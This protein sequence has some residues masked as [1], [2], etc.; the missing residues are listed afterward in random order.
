MNIYTYLLALGALAC[1]RPAAATGDSLRYLVSTDTVM[2]EIA[3]DQR[4]YTQHTFAPKQTL[5]S[6]S[7]FYAQDIDQLIELNP[8]L[9]KAQP[10]IGQTVKVAVP[11]VAITRY[12]TAGF[13]ESQYSKVCYTVRPGET[14][15]KIAR[16]IFRMPVDTL[17]AVNGLS[18]TTLSPG[19]VLQVG[20]MNVEGAASKIETRPLDPLQRVSH[21]NFAQ[22]LRQ[23]SKVH[24]QRHVASW[25]PG[26]GEA[27]GQLFAL[28]NGVEP[29]TYL[30]V[31]NATNHRTAYVRV[32]GSPANNTRQA[33]I[34][35]QLSGTAA[36][37]LGATE[38]NFYVIVE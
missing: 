7:R 38:R 13:S 5:Y 33:Q 4:K 3:P 18:T 37:V 24:K 6:L 17:M 36:R 34:D 28:V 12:R 32:I 23:G 19:Q 21:G 29:G 16:T 20:W 9:A 14:M 31:T 22:Y 8:V 25:T 30:K 10:N 35:M 26:T 11:N 27:S 1:A 2:L 15:Y